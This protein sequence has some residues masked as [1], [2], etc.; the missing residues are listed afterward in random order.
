MSIVMKL[1][2]TAAALAAA[3][4]PAGTAA[5][6]QSSPPAVS[7]VVAMM[8]DMGGMPMKDNMKKSQPADPAA[9]GMGGMSSGSSMPSGAADAPV[10]GM[11]MMGKMRGSGMQSRRGQ[12]MASSTALPGFPG[13]SRLYH[14]GATDFFLDHPQ[15]ATLSIEQQTSINRIKERALLDKASA[16]RR[17]EQ[18]E[19]ELFQLTGAE[20]PDAARIDAKVREIEK[21]RGDSRMAYI[22]AVG[23]AARQLT[24]EQRGAVLGTAP[25]AKPAGASPAHGSVMPAPSAQ[26]MPSQTK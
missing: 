16:D 22:R 25:A 15:H 1:A 23:E 2:L 7:V 20:S 21:L 24:P 13:A 14:V 8:D 17:I 3:L 5:A 18:A 12:P 26:G 4:G 6:T 9:G 10:S 11:D 19:Q